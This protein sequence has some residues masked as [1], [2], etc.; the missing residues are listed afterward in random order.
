MSGSAVDEVEV[1]GIF[2]GGLPV[3]VRLNRKSEL[4][5][6]GRLICQGSH[7]HEPLK[8]IFIW[9]ERNDILEAK[10]GKT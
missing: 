9:N 5:K 1:F 10:L 4:K 6:I 8:R 2:G 7:M 3:S